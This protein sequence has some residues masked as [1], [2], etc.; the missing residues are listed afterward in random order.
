MNAT[1]VVAALHGSAVFREDM[2]EARAEV[3]RAL[4]HAKA[5]T[6]CDAEAEALGAPLW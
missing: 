2:D 6:G 5:P 4:K 3:A 1:A